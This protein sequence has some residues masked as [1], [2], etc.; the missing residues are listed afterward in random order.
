MLLYLNDT[1]RTA[2]GGWQVS[3]NAG[4]GKALALDEPRLADLPKDDE[5]VAGMALSDRMWLAWQDMRASTRALID[6]NPSEARLLFFVLLSDVI[7]FLSR[8]LSLV[9]APGSAASKFLPLEIGL[10]LIGV[11]ILR[12][13]TLYAFSGLVGL[14]G[15]ALGGQGSWRETRTG[16]F[17]ASLV[18][19][20]VGVLGALIGAGFGHLEEHA[21]IFGT[22][23]FVIA[24][25]TL[26]IVAFVWF[27]SAG[28]AEAHRFTRTSLVFIAF[29]V[30]AVVLAV[31]G[32][33]LYAQVAYA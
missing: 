15:R 28:V 30:L 13:A 20:P 19:A 3:T 10:W 24:P 27:V 33:A 7:F 23:L 1:F 12:T 8:T 6:E 9:V 2:T 32:I 29:S 26:G 22:D 5:P 18:A 14:V 16:V 4:P 21:P 17:W 11:L 25:L 31:A